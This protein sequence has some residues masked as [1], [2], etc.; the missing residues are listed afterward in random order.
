[1]QTCQFPNS[2]FLKCIQLLIFFII[3]DVN[4]E[5]FWKFWGKFYR[6]MINRLI[7]KIIC[8]PLVCQ[9]KYGT[10][11]IFF[12]ASQPFMPLLKSCSVI[13]SQCC[14]DTVSWTAWFMSAACAPHTHTC[15]H[16]PSNIIY[17]PESHNVGSHTNTQPA[18]CHCFPLPDTDKKK[19]GDT[20]TAILF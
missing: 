12:P 8:K 3:Y 10:G 15:T 5:L 6:Q 14:N 13:L 4:K 19:V 2:N 7:M 17:I 9:V 18:W 20:H 16:T 1:M 11:N